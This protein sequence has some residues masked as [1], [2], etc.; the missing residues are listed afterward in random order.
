MRPPAPAYPPAARRR[1]RSGSLYHRSF[2]VGAPSSA[3]AESIKGLAIESWRRFGLEEIQHLSGC[4][5]RF[6]ELPQNDLGKT[7]SW[8]LAFLQ[9][10]MRFFANG[11]RLKC[12][13]QKLHKSFRM[14][15]PNRF[16]EHTAGPGRQSPLNVHAAP[17]EL[18]RLWM[19]FYNHGAPTELCADLAT[20]FTATLG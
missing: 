3:L 5:E 2:A 14:G 12:H 9:P 10:L 18:D 8:Q 11:Q 19:V 20:N 6:R 13:T 17:T 1:D 16:D 15:N 4:F 7:F